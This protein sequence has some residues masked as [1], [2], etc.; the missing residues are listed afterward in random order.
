M[1]QKLVDVYRQ[2]ESNFLEGKH[3]NALRAF[4]NVIRTDPGHL[5][6]RFQVGRTLEAMKEKNRAFEVY[7]ALASHC[8]KAGFPLLGLDATKRASKLQAGFE[9]TLHVLADNYGIESDMV[10][11][12]LP[13]PPPHALKEELVS[14]EESIPAEKLLNTA[15][16][17]AKSFEDVR[18]PKQLPPAPLFS[19]LIKEAIYP[20]L[21]ILELHTYQTGETIV[22]EG[23]P[24][25]SVYLL[26]HGEV[27]VREGREGKPRTLARIT[28]GSIFGEMALIT[29]APRV[30]SAVAI[31]ESDILELSREDLEMVA[32]DIDDVTL[33]LARFVR[34]RFL[35]NLLLTS[36]VFAPFSWNDK[37]QILE[38]FTSVGIP[39]DEVV[40]REGTV[41]SGLYMIL[42][43]EV[44]VSKF[45]GASRVHLATLK[46]GSVFGEIS[47]VNDSPTTATVRATRGGEFLFLP[48]E[49]FQDL[50]AE[51]PEIK[52]NL[53][54]L[55][56][57]RLKNQQRAVQDAKIITQDG[58]ILF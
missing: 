2:A 45:E 14:K 43:G 9:G 41:G 12:K 49:D 40:I 47:L 23:D 3:E 27:E 42:G 37:Q 44:E 15:A 22:K 57:E 50:A 1:S 53:A 31:A 25:T 46:E 20:I 56:E 11:Q 13:L 4:A 24:G 55:S 48:R 28:T 26:A 30:A 52:T 8:L 32:N 54:T 21:Q 19:L 38:R 51:R 18:Y 6:S 35:N 7:K 17:L 34:Q 10:D 5:W 16:Q 58:E 39:T 36:P 29:D 33:A